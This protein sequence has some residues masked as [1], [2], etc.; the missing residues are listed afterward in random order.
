LVSRMVWESLP[1]RVTVPYVKTKWLLLGTCAKCSAPKA[2]TE[3]LR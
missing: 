3:R 2:E 1:E